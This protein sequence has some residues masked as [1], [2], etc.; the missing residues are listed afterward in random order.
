MAGGD[1]D[2][3]AL[4]RTLVADT[5]AERRGTATPAE[6]L[7]A[8]LTPRPRVPGDD[9]LASG[10]TDSLLGFDLD[11]FTLE[12]RLGQG[13]MGTVYLARD[14][15]LDRRVALKMLREDLSQRSGHEERFLREARAQ[16]RLTHPN[17]VQIYYIGHRPKR[18]DGGGGALYFAMELVEGGSLEESITR[19]EKLAPEDARRAMIEVARGLRAAHKAGIIHRDVKPSN[20]LRDANGFIKIADFGLAKPL[21]QE[22]EAA[23]TQEGAM[24]G[25][26]A[27]MAPEQARGAPLDARCD[28]YALGACFYH[29][30]TGEPVFTGQSALAVIAKHLT[31]PIT[32]VATR[33]PEVPKKLAAIL[34]RLL[35]K[36]REKRYADYDGLLDDLEAA[37]PHKVEYAGFWT[38]AAAVLIDLML[39][40]GLVALLDWPGMVLHL[41][42]VTLGHAYFGQTIAKYFLRIRVVRLDGTRLGLARAFARTLA[43][44]WFFVIAGGSVA[45]YSGY[46]KLLSIVELV[47]PDQI[48]QAQQ[49]LIAGA[50]SNGMLTLLFS[51][52][53]L[54][55]AFQRQKRAFHDLLVG[56]MVVYTVGAPRVAPA[57]PQLKPP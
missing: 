38:R 18:A 42:H 10:A 33:A 48:D 3:E 53:L 39:A 23:I 50:I 28:M 40:A 22:G 44:L 32:P 6:R 12:R 57:S 30:V 26:P 11:H 2:S 17:V 9:A 16:A 5:P 47:R 20:L 19:G 1:E 43:S 14:R 52:G 13:G 8:A 34:E 49:L 35:Q 15:S 55:A 27:Y 54:L 46:G 41:A 21:E 56:S 31:Q 4:A 51:A 36:D 45:L 29:L 25:S 24:I 7:A 37:A